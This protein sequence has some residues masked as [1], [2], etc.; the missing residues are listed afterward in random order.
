MKRTLSLLLLPFLLPFLG[1]AQVL[2]INPGVHIIVTGAPSLVLNNA[3]VANYGNFTAGNSTVFF[4]GDRYSYIGGDNPMAFYNLTVNLPSGYL[5][6]WN[7][8]S[9]SGRITLDNGNLQLNTYTLNL[10]ATGSIIGERNDACITGSNGGTVTATALLNAP[11]AANPGNIGVEITSSANLGQTL[12]TRGHI[13]QSNAPGQTGIQ[14]YFD[15]APSLHTDAP[16]TLRFYYF[17]GELAGYSKDGL[18]L[19]SDTPGQS[20]WI[21]RGKDNSDGINNWVLKNNMPALQRFTLAL[22]PASVASAAA[23]QV[24]PNPS[25]NA[26]TI[27]LYSA[28]EKDGV[29]SLRDQ[30]G[31]LLQSKAIH[32]QP[33]MNK[34]EWN[35]SSYAAGAYNLVFDR[36]DVK[37]TTVVK[38]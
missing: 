18:N 29:V 11:Y 22:A 24:Y 38:Q 15:I 37:N 9:V 30:W 34:I 1:Q 14:R 16:A 26:F 19:F 2:R 20:N 13:Q 17:D 8:A 6:L 5:Q 35:I 33:G 3:P 23:V 21:V 25:R 27:L 31:R 10:G 32:C 12:I 28:K 7:N 36:L 4:T